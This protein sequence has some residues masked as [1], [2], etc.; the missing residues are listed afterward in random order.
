MFWGEAARSCGCS[1]PASPRRPP[2]R[3]LPSAVVTRRLFPDRSPE[4]RGWATSP[5]APSPALEEDEE[6]SQEAKGMRGFCRTPPAKGRGGKLRL[7][8]GSSLTSDCVLF[9]GDETKSK[10]KLPFFFS[11][12]YFFLSFFVTCLVLLTLLY[13][14][15][16]T[17]WIP[18]FPLKRKL[19]PTGRDVLV[20][21][22]R[23]LKGHRI[24]GRH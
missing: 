15:V 14:V 23:R 19:K 22:G 7:G 12:F 5:Q 4:N 21:R 9:C 11:L 2:G 8:T 3:A 17:E 18:P 10:T 13:S 24:W 16:K 6:R 1:V 20:P